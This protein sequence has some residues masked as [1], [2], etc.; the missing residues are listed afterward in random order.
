MRQVFNALLKELES[1]KAAVLATI[2]ASEGSTPRKAG[3]RM[4]VRED[5]SICGTVGGGAVEYQTILA[6]AKALELKTSFLR[7][8]CLSA[9]QAASI[10]M[11]C[12]GKVKVYLQ[13]LAPEEPE[14]RL[15]REILDS[16]EQNR[17]GFLVL[18]ITA[19]E[20]WQM[21]ITHGASEPGTAVIKASAPG[22]VTDKAASEM[23]ASFTA[24]ADKGVKSYAFPLVKTGTVYIFGGGHVAQELVP[25]L[26]HLDFCCIVIDDRAEFSCAQVFPQA[27]QTLVADLEH[28]GDAVTIGPSDYV[29]IMTRGHQ[30]DY[31]VQ[32]QVML[33]QPAYIGVMGSRNKI[34][35][36]TEKL[37]KDGFSRAEIEA[38][39]MPI[40]TDIKAE[41]PAEIAVSIAG[42]L[43]AVRAMRHKALL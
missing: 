35:V 43:I 4:M 14:I 9:E 20:Q 22:A 24:A 33:W 23:A 28:L 6:A 36:V 42:E 29:C 7:W 32:K 34:R 21:T 27:E 2:V 11:V 1:G 18:D 15:C 25:V 12:G 8:F 3:A 19:D 26:S 17:N 37:L 13:Y 5:G 41:T 38:C 10:G 39:H 30:F 16:L 31:Y 40:G